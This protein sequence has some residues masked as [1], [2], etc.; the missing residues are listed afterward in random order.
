MRLLSAKLGSF[1]AR[2][3][4]YGCELMNA[5]YAHGMIAEESAYNNSQHGTLI[6][7]SHHQS[8]HG[9]SCRAEL[10]RRK[11]SK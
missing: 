3:L 7:I 8:T 5:V 1:L 2:A 11:A 4:R 6:A 9:A 10:R